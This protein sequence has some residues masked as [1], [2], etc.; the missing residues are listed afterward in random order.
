V[1]DNKDT[2]EKRIIELELE[3][4]EEKSL[5]QARN[6]LLV[7]NIKELNEVYDALREKLKELQRRNEKIR[8]LR[9]SLSKQTSFQPSVNWQAPLPTK[10]R[11]LLSL[12]R[13]LPGG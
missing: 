10:L 11:T 13:D 7:A 9:N 6:R 1:A 8:I 2:A 5:S 4:E 3:L 12:S